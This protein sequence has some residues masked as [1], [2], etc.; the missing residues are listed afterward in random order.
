MLDTLDRFKAKAFKPNHAQLVRYLFWDKGIGYDEF[1]K[2]P[3]PY[4][5]EILQTY[6]YMKTEEEKAY[7]KA[8]KK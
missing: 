7:K 6:T 3:L 5:F 1:N 8:K 4:I 2:M